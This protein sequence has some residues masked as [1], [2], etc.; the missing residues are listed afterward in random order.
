MLCG[1]TVAILALWW[2]WTLPTRADTRGTGVAEG[3]RNPKTVSSSHVCSC[4][5]V[6]LVSVRRWPLQDPVASELNMNIGQPMSVRCYSKMD[7]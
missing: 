4:L 3:Q 7:K 2:K 1:S 6:S 5:Q